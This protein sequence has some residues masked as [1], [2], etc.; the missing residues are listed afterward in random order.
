MKIG[1][2][3]LDKIL[4]YGF[5]KD[6]KDFYNRYKDKYDIV[7]FIDNYC[8]DNIIPIY[9]I[10][11]I[12]ERFKNI[13]IVIASSKYGLEMAEQLIDMGYT[14]GVDAYFSWMV[15][16]K[17]IAL[18]H[19]NC[20]TNNIR[21]ILLCNNEFKSDYTFVEF[22]RIFSC[23]CIAAL[24]KYK[25]IGVFNICDLL[26]IQ[27]IND[28]NKFGYELS[29]NNVIKLVGDKCKIVRILILSFSG[30]FPQHTTNKNIK[31][32]NE[33]QFSGLFP[34]GDINV[35]RYIK[36]G[37]MKSDILNTIIK[38]DYYSKECIDKLILENFERIKIQDDMSDIKIG[39]YI[40]NNY[41]K[42]LLFYSWLHPINELILELTNRILTYLDY[43]KLDYSDIINVGTLKGQDEAIYPS[44]MIN[45]FGKILDLKYYTNRYLHGLKKINVQKEYDFKEFIELYID[46]CFY[47][48]YDEE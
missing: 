40:Y 9:K 38:P 48:L 20:Q 21:E 4:I 16:G 13:K 31:F 1:I 24:N 23:N 34:C 2:S 37:M 47:G 26:I 33:E 19:G 45:I 22:P 5:G 46:V 35:E 28:D 11:D 42:K 32:A 27:N 39:D 43:E 44:T 36:Q 41:N 18:I 15:E 12:D 6:G 7:G 25:K 30:Y 10:G 14:L 17:K 3:N 29:A 8:T